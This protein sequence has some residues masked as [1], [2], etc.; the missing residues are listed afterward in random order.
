MD[1]KAEEI[2][3]GKDDNGLMLKSSTGPSDGRCERCR[4]HF[5][6][7]KPFGKSGDP[8]VGNVEGLFFVNINRTLVPYDP[9]SDRLWAEYFDKCQ[10]Q[11]DKEEARKAFI[12]QFGEEELEQ[13]EWYMYLSC[14]LERFWL[15]RD[16]VILD[17]WEFWRVEKPKN[18]EEYCAKWQTQDDEEEVHFQ[19]ITEKDLEFWST[20]D[21]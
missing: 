13:L 10:T 18:W 9:E 17:A 2:K 4:R 8:L 1:G 14:Q 19:E 21:G 6:E 3:K 5:S 20:S 15:C 11:D 12:Q 16:C 7:L